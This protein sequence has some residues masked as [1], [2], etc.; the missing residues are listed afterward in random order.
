[1]FYSWCN[2]FFAWWRQKYGQN[3]S[4]IQSTETDLILLLLFFLLKEK[5]LLIEQ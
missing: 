5:F 2:Q 4:D 3:V 1:M